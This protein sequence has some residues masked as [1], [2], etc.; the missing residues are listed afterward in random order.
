MKRLR[1]LLAG[2]LCPVV[3]ASAQTPSFPSG[4][5]FDGAVP[6]PGTFLGRPL[7]ER[8]ARAAEVYGYVRILAETSPRVRI[9]EMG[10]TYEGRTILYAVLSSAENIVRLD[11]IRQDNARLGN[12]RGLKDGEIRALA[13]EQP[14]VVWAEYAIHGDEISSVDA[15]LQVLYQ[16]AAGTDSATVNLLRSLV[17]CIDPMVNP[18]GR[19]RFLSQMEQWR[20]PVP[21]PDAQSFHHTGMWPGGRGNHYLFDLN[22]DWFILAHPEMQARVKA[23][24]G[25]NP[26]VVIDSHEMGSSDTYLF[27]P[28]REPLNPNISPVPLK[29]WK[30]FAADQAKAFD[31]YGWSYYTREWN[32]DW[33]PGY[34]S[35]WI[36]YRS[37]I[38]ILYEQAGVDGSLVRRPD[39]SLL[40]YPETV[41]HHVTST[42]AN[43]ET[44]A[45]NRRQI[46]EDFAADRRAVAEDPHAETYYIVPGANGTRRVRLFERLSVAG[47]EV[48]TLERQA[49][50]RE[51]RDA[52]GMKHPAMTFPAGTILVS[53]AQP[54][55][56]YAR[57]ILEFDPRMKKAFLEEERKSLEKEGSSKLYD[58]TAWSLLLAA[59][60]EAY[61]SWSPPPSASRAWIPD[62]VRGLVEQPGATYG[63]LIDYADDRAAEALA[64]LLQ[65]GCRV[66]SA[67]E[68]LTVEGRS[69]GR[70]A[71]LLRRNENPDTLEAVLHAAAETTGIRIIGVSTAL[72]SAG[73]DLGGNDMVLLHAPRPAIVA[74]PGFDGTSFGATWYLLDQKLRLQTSIIDLQHLASGDCRKYN[75]LI[76]PSGGSQILAQALGKSGRARL[77]EWTE[78]GGTLIA[79]GG[80]AAFAA[81]TASGL[82][83]V[84]L[85]DQVLKDR[86]LYD[87]GADLEMKAGQSTLDSVAFW[88]GAFE[89][90]DTGRTVRSSPAEEKALAEADERARRFAPR[91]SILQ[92][93]LDEEFWMSFGEGK[94]VP[95]LVSGP[96][97]FLSRRPVRTPA[98]LA[99][100]GTLRLSGLL[101][102]E[103][104]ERFERSAYA[105]REAC[106]RGQIILFAGQPNARASFE[107]AERLLINALLLGPGW[108]SQ[109]PVDW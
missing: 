67:R 59:N 79:I 87:R 63:F 13:A 20:G 17:V 105:T 98:R 91:G 70:G 68:G 88:S 77:R 90:A 69:Y 85:R 2:L 35:S 94:S 26:Q 21:N 109:Q 92:A 64:F 86:D 61:V 78:Q 54:L 97:V 60:C 75:V 93:I 50:V 42:M 49:Q 6:S 36:L 46:L 100:E 74:G 62:D 24:A 7:A 44:A 80:S 3:C 102:Q 65:R 106:G 83:A 33:Y 52:R 16:L 9:V 47:I 53:C 1:Y 39:G 8:P 30:T 14:L 31:R 38:G 76:L 84:R 25:W 51:V 57:A 71:L 66:R 4:G 5:T 10:R 18:D 108:G 15:A 37:A 12:G 45:R 11:R 48:R 27:H 81:D 82:S 28:P 43:L 104:R 22:R 56:R 23:I 73:P 89:P 55:G 19:E 101:W 29:W 41:Q 72:S 34:G 58:N 107:G 103:A 96:T 40:T 99:Q 95:V 32:D